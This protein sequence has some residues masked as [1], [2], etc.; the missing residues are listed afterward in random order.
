MSAIKSVEALSNIALSHELFFESS[1]DCVKVLDIE[2]NLLSMNRNGQ[3]LMEIDDF[4]R[5]CGLPWPSLWPEG[6]QNVLHAALA[7][8]REGESSQFFEFCPTAKGTGK[9]WDVR[10]TP[11]YDANAK[12]NGF[13]SVSRDITA[14][15]EANEALTRNGRFANG[16]KQALERAVQGAPLREVLEILTETAEAYTNKTM[17]ASVLLLDKDGIHLRLGAAPSLPAP[18]N[19]AIDGMAIGP[20]VG[21]CGTA[22][23][24]KKPVFVRD[25]Q[26]DPKCSGVKELTAAHGLASCWSYPMLSSQGQVLGT[27]AFYFKEV[28]DPSPLELE[29]MPMLV[30]T[31]ALVLERLHEAEERKVAEDAFKTS[32]AK[33][34]AIT[35]A[36]PQMVWSTHPNGYA[37]YYNEQWYEFTGASVGA[38][39]GEQ[40][41]NVL[42]PD[43]QQR[44]AQAWR[45]SLQTGEK[46]EIEYRLRHSSGEYRWSLARAL[47]VKDEAGEIIRWIGTC[48]DIH[49]QKRTQEKLQEADRRKDEFLAML[50]HELR[51]P[52]A[53]IS[54]AA[55]LLRLAKLDEGR[56]E[57]VSNVISRQASHMTG[58]IEDLL[59]VSR[60]TRGLV[61]LDKSPID[62]KGIVAEA[63]E[64]VLPLVEARSHHLD[65]HIPAV[66]AIVS[67]DKKRLVQ[68]LANVLG[69]AA[70]YTPN[71]GQIALAMKVTD[72]KV[73]LTVRDNGIG[74]SRDL[75]ASAFE[76]FRQG[77]RTP[78][79]SQGGLGIGLALVKSLV[80][81][82]GG[83]IEAYSN[84]PGSGSEF[85]V[86]LPRLKQDDKSYHSKRHETILNTL[87]KSLKVLIV[88]DNVDAA[89][90]LAM[91]L[92]EAG[93]KV[94][95]EYKAAKAL[96]RAGEV[97]P[98]VCLLDI[99]LPDMCGN[100]LVKHLQSMPG[101]EATTMV[102]VTGYGQAHDKE[103][104]LGS[105]FK[106]H[107]VKP[108]ELKKV[109]ELLE[110][111]ARYKN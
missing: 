105:G 25:T 95:V 85:T 96:S 44:T 40:W 61:S 73:I 2:G 101:L 66:S 48:T 42:H 99:G 34:R 63:V 62:I 65:T 92:E 47:P 77:E 4:T 33:F 43:D 64:Q 37:E 109:L 59:D 10:V 22:A 12:L 13:L 19:H 15:H 93:H 79:R 94:F 107:F 54:A 57:A 108:V 3:C 21:S 35:N 80:Q 38:T 16:Q 82:H 110:V 81:L 55:D 53:P 102:A 26:T 70:K 76:L 75:V 18:F 17:L 29:A 20:S 28:R 68:I 69:N 46:Y 41:Q 31:A 84:G 45:H 89:Q 51:N 67:G 56:L 72:D 91:I 90:L 27:F 87:N 36:M 23:Y 6:S 86:T 30:H 111:I 24:L 1:P 74:M 83:T 39:D 14:L 71:G 9:W 103:L 7:R 49:E 104:S 32:D 8:A 88:D 58:L 97:M 78:D 60:V 11:I 106:H 5:I 98:D 52:L 50:A 100:E